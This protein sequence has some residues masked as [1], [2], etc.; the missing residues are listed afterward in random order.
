MDAL[1][2]SQ[3]RHELKSGERQKLIHLSAGNLLRG[4]VRVS[5]EDHFG[6]QIGRYERGLL[7]FMSQ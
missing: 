4:S 6:N 3:R 2:L 7:T 1:I 5:W